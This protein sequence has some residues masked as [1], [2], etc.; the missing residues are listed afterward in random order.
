[1]QTSNKAKGNEQELLEPKCFI[2]PPLGDFDRDLRD[3]PSDDKIAVPE[4]V[5]CKLTKGKGLTPLTL[6]LYVERCLIFLYA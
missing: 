4:C 6:L 1:M 3:F 2:M 5:V